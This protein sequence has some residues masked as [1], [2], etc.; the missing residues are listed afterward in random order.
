[1]FKKKFVTR[2][3]T[4]V[5]FREPKKSDAEGAM[6]CINAFVNEKRSGVNINKKVTLKEEKGWITGMLAA[7]KKKQKVMLVIDYKGK[8][9]GACTIECRRW[10]QSHMAVL[11]IAIS[12]GFRERGIGTALLK[13]AIR[14]A[15][16]RMKGLE[17]IELT[18]VSYNKRSRHVYKKVGFKQVAIIPDSTKERREYFDQP[19]MYLYLKN[20]KK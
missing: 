2:D 1:M 7:V 13:E 6:K 8:Y 17:I 20:W 10:K 16:K 19:L 15:K 12:R 3:G 5:L 18:H 14:L 9:M 11:G 4:E